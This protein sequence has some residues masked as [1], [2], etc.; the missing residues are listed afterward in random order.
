MLVNNDDIFSLPR[1]LDVDAFCEGIYFIN[2]VVTLT[3]IT[4]MCCMLIH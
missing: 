1:Y 2:P 3:T 4:G